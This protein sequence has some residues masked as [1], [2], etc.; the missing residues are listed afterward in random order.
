[1]AADTISTHMKIDNERLTVT[2]TIFYNGRKIFIYPF[3]RI[4]I[5]FLLKPPI[6]AENYQPNYPP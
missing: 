5:A 6:D 4:M 3:N 1:M 2:D